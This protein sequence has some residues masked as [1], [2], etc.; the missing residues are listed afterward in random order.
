MMKRYDL[1]LHFNFTYLL[2]AEIVNR[3]L[4]AVIAS[5]TYL[6]STFSPTLSVLKVRVLCVETKS[7][8]GWTEPFQNANEMTMTVTS[9]VYTRHSLATATNHHELT[10]FFPQKI[11]QFYLNSIVTDNS[12]YQ[13]KKKAKPS[14]FAFDVISTQLFDF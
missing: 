12:I 5:I 7:P 3:C 13:R 11:Q 4:K 2:F 1:K 14:L 6:I 10:D 9:Q 8:I